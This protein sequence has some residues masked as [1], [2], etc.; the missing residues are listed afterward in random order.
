ML[1]QQQ[2]TTATDGDS[3][4][5]ES[6]YSKL[7]NIDLQEFVEQN[8]AT[9]SFPEKLMILLMHL[10]KIFP[11]QA[12][13]MKNA[14]AGWLQNGGAFFIRDKDE[15]TAK[16]LPLFFEKIKFSSFTRKRK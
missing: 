12:E 16:W 10:D 8:N 2:A 1:A 11:T 15:L 14:P 6:Q 4:A 7:E 3:V 9:L 13:R 5:N